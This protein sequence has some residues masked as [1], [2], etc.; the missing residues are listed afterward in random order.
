ML[1]D[2][3]SSGKLEQCRMQKM[4]QARG[5]RRQIMAHCE[6]RKGD[7]QTGLNIRALFWNKES[8]EISKQQLN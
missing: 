7:L 6:Q 1:P 2:S 4:E 5:V 8:Q 3:K